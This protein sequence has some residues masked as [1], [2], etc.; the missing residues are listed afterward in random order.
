MILSSVGSTVLEDVV[1]AAPESLK[2]IQVYIFKSR[3][4][5]RN[6]V[7]RAEKAGY[8]AIVVTVDG[9]VIGKRLT[10]FQNHSLLQPHLIHLPNIEASQIS[11]AKKSSEH[12]SGLAFNR[13]ANSMV[14]ASIS[15]EIVDW[16][17]S[18]TKLPI[19]LK[20]ILTADDAREAV[21]FGVDAVIVSNTGGRQLDYVPATVSAYK[22]VGVLSSKILR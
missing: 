13:F 5:T 22:S 1:F 8:K 19:I 6:I 10:D 2:W 21:A 3:E 11:E 12:R 16:L 20:G 17:K 9:G 14:D 4:V 18:I 15:F 7:E